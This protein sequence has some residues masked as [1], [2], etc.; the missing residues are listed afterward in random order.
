MN[1]AAGGGGGNYAINESNELWSWGN[2]ASGQLALNDT[3]KRSSPVQVGSA[4]GWQAD[5][6]SLGQ[7]VSSA[8]L[9]E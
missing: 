4:T 1:G 9:E 2:N 6:L 8:T 5:T 7:D 3:A